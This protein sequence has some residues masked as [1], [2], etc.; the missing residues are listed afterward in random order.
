MATIR[1]RNGKWQVQIRRSGARHISRSFLVRKDADAWA[2]QM[3]VNAD[4]CD[5][6]PDTRQLKMITLGDL[7]RRYRSEMTPKK[8]GVAIESAV[9]RKFLR[10]P[11]SVCT[12]KWEVGP[13]P[14]LV[15]PRLRAIVVP[16]TS[17]GSVMADADWT[18][19]YEGLARH[20]LRHPGRTSSE[21]LSRS[22]VRI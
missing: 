1:R 4:R 18:R 6:P 12:V 21:F 5:L 2:R 13:L 20:S 19:I 14:K 16:T 9:L 7:V 8:L 3:E 10:D 15:L 22:G 11:I 17:R